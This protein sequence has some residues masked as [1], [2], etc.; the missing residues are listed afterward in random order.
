MPNHALF[1]TFVALASLLTGCS[2]SRTSSSNP[3]PT[4][5][6]VTLYNQSCISCHSTGAAGA[7]RAHDRLAW[8]PRLEQGMDTL[9]E[10]TKKGVAAMPPMGMCMQCSDEDFQALIVFMS[11]SQ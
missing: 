9:L 7:P 5:P 11:S 8:Q 1:I 10:N 4:N 3:Q 2:D 6:V